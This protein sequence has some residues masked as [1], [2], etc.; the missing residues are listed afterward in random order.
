MFTLNSASQITL[1]RLS[2]KF[3]MLLRPPVAHRDV[4][5]RQPDGGRHLLLG[6]GRHGHQ[7]SLGHKGHPVFSSI[8]VEGKFHLQ[9]YF[10][11]SCIIRQK[12]I[13]KSRVH[14]LCLT[15]QGFGR[16][17]DRVPGV[18]QQREPPPVED[19]TDQDQQ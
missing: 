2:L 16:Q 8:Y 6:I 1:I 4:V 9:I 18:E 17:A 11:L 12:G 19:A 15:S 7:L 14:D 10:S 5:D 3:K 13:M